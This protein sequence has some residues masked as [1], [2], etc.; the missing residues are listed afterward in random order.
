VADITDGGKADLDRLVHTIKARER[1][2]H[3]IHII[4]FTDRLGS[5]G[6]NED[7]SQKRA[8]AVMNYLV[9]HG[10]PSELIEAEGR[11]KMDAVKVCPPSDLRSLIACLAPN[12]RVVVV[13]NGADSEPSGKARSS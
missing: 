5:D 9:A 4:G 2:V 13:I 8:F 12:R 1:G 11:G 6:Y 7:L 3:D 10:I